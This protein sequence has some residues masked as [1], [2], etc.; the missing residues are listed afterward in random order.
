MEKSYNIV[1]GEKAGDIMI[2]VL[3]IGIGFLLGALF[4]FVFFCVLGWISE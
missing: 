4:T 3:S 1:F 2:D